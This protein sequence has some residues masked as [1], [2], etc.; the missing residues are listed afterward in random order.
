MNV[1]HIVRTFDLSGRSRMIFQLAEGLRGRGVVSTV[2]V[3]SNSAG[4]A[5]SGLEIV[6]LGGG[7]GFDPSLAGRVAAL[8]RRK[9]CDV[10][11]SH[12]RGAALHAAL[13]AGWRR[14][15]PL[16]HTVHRSDG[17]P[18][19]GGALV[20]RWLM[21][22]TDCVAAV[23]DAARLAFIEANGFPAA[24]TMT[25]Y[26]GVEPAAFSPRA[27]DAASATVI[28]AVANLSPD[29]DTAT[30]LQAFRLLLRKRPQAELW[31]V[32]DGP[33][34]EAARTLCTTLGLTAQVKF[35]GFRNDV[36]RLLSNFNV[37][38]H[39]TRTEGMGI[40]I[41]EAMAAGVPVAASRVG[42]IPEIVEDG[43][44]GRLVPPGDD[45]ALAAAIE[46][47]LDDA[48]RAAEMARRAAL[49][50]EERFT[51]ARMCE[52]YAS[53]YGRLTTRKT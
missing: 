28:G 5:P 36:P 8:A 33:A 7:E 11:H 21:A 29:K 23:S 46:E 50:V 20:R 44:T 53:L 47:L 26:N 27:A 48:Q 22:R 1:L 51:V 12:G 34:G 37:L 49:R 38:A 13:A 25:I 31:I 42:G 40:A 2:A 4:F 45:R 39:S 30:L 19:P 41:L 24:R 9:D 6:P 17:D 18:L 10:L 43:I 16:V 35:L 15:R 32:G 52:A 3:L 14:R